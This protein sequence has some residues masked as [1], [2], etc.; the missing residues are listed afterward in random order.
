[1]SYTPEQLKDLWKFHDEDGSGKIPASEL[2]NL[3][4]KLGSDDETSEMKAKVNLIYG[5]F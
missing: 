3:F 5:T 4:K 2:K 1:M